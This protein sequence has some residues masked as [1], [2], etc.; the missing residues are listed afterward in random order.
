MDIQVRKQIPVIDEL[1]DRVRWLEQ[2][3]AS[4]A[5]VGLSNLT[6]RVNVL[7]IDAQTL[8]DGAVTTNQR[9]DQQ[10][11]AAAASPTG[12]NRESIPK[13]DGLP[14]FCDATKTDPIPW[15]R[16]FELKLDTHHAINPN[17]HAYLYSRSGGACQAWLDKLSPHNVAVSE[18]HTK[19]SWSDLK[20]A[21]HKR[22][23][24]EPTEL[25]AAEKLQ[26]FYQNDLPSTDWI[27]E[28]QRLASTPILPSTFFAIKHFFIRMSCPALQNALM[29]VAET[30][31]TSEQL[32]DKASQIILTNIEAKNLG[33]SSAAGQ[34][35]GQHRPKVAVVAATTLT[36]PSNE[37]APSKEGDRLAAARDG[38]RPS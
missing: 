37:T 28:Y 26:R 35:R 34:G 31:T 19:I 18:L 16:Q 14:I 4:A 29:Q 20:A 8:K 32:F 27:T 12:T 36:D 17:R 2:Q 24:V 7:E 21:W 38:D 9:I 13:F 30:L 22:F 33:R 6:D 25:Q 3:L 23:Q 15:W 1:L 10:I 5:P 11:C